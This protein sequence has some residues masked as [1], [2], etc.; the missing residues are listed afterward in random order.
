MRPKRQTE[1]FC[2]PIFGRKRE[3]VEIKMTEFVLSLIDL[4]RQT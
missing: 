3:K 2:D 4:L 1:D